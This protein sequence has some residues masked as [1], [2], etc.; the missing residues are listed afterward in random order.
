M[1]FDKKFYA[2]L[3]VVV[4]ILLLLPNLPS[5]FELGNNNFIIGV[6]T[7]IVIISFIGIFFIGLFKRVKKLGKVEISHMKSS[8]NKVKPNIRIL[9]NKLSK[10]KVNKNEY[11]PNTHLH[12]EEPK[13]YKN[14]Y[15]HSEEPSK[16]KTSSKNKIKSS[17]RF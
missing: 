8:F 12:S 2:I 11:L 14:T 3:F 1:N 7:C 5:V 13:K 6:L 16:N 9:S 4:L 10:I 15:Y 17:G